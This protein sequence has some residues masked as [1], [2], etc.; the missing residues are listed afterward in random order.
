MT[1]IVEQL[2]IASLRSEGGIHGPS[3]YALRKA[4]D[5]IERLQNNA[6]NLR[7][8]ITDL[9]GVIKRLREELY[10]AMGARGDP[11]DKREIDRLRAEREALRDDAMRYRWLRDEGDKT[12]TPMK[13]RFSEGAKGCDAAIDAAR[14][15]P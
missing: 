3:G 5:E 7:Q 2:R 11:E 13:N 14:K 8:E 6:D 12:W 15:Q 4:A 10:A 1:D 9:Q